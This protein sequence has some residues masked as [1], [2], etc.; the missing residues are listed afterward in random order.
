MKKKILILIPLLLLLNHNAY[1]SERDLIN[2]QSFF[3]SKKY[4]EARKIFHS[5]YITNSKKPIAA[6]ALLGVA[7]CDYF[8]KRYYESR[9]NLRRILSMTQ[10]SDIL[11][12]TNLYLGNV[13]LALSRYKLAEKYYSSV[14]GNLKTDA[15]IGLAEAALRTNDIT[16]ADTLL[17]TLKTVDLQIR[18][19]G[20]AVKAMIESLKGK[21]ESAINSIKLIDPKV[22]KDL[23]LSIEKA[24]IYFFADKL[25][26]AE[27]QLNEILKR[28]DT[29]NV[30]RL[31]AMRVLWQIYQKENRIDEAIKIGMKMLLYENSDNFYLSMAS[32]FDKKGD[33]GGAL[34]VLSYM[35]SKKLKEQEIEKRLKVAFAKK[36][37]AL[38]KYLSRYTNFVS[39]DSPF[40]VDIARYI[41]NENDKKRAIEILKR[42]SKGHAAGAAALYLS[43]LLIEEK[44]FTEAKKALEFMTLDPRYARSASLM[45]GD[46]LYKEGRVNEA[47]NYYK[48]LVDTFSD[49]R[50]AEKL[51]EILINQ[52]NK[53][54]ANKY[55]MI[56]SDRGS[57]KASIKVGDYYYVNGDTKK[58]LE[59]YKRALNMKKDDPDYY[60]LNYQ[61]GKITGQKEYL[62]RASTG[63]GEIAEAAKILLRQF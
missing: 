29:T 45:L 23:D 14:V 33:I 28:P 19:R 3:S 4:S 10:D 35:N 60:W 39:E 59:Y 16:K 57:E 5:V 22:I 41:A 21:H 46:I 12:E 38:N 17:K 54:E 55:Y 36:D 56:A 24:Q 43:E 2:A 49:T 61:Y 32:L 11:N 47:I 20:V 51:G 7:K 1:S 44:R 58:A 42:A 50:V 31:R 62:I 27:E 53:D 37:P 52:G 34:Q 40:L 18:P 9:E 26:D 8:L 6:K 13:N 15:T 30:N 63:S 25:K 48:K